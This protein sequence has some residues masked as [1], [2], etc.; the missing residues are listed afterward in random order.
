MAGM[1]QTGNQIGVHKST[2]KKK[3]NCRFKDEKKQKTETTN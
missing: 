3:I 1:V 2:F